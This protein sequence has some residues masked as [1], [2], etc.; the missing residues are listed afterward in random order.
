MKQALGEYLYSLVSVKPM[1]FWSLTLV[2]DLD[3]VPRSNSAVISVPPAIHVHLVDLAQEVHWLTLH[4]VN[5][6]QLLH[7]VDVSSWE[8]IT[9]P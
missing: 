1:W 2:S 5:I 6:L 4:R 8:K 9:K 3:V 7:Y